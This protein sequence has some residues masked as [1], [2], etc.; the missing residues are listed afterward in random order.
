M[1]SANESARRAVRAL[2][3][4]DG[5]GGPPVKLIDIDHLGLLED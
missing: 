5:Y 1:E 4:A 3:D 2:L